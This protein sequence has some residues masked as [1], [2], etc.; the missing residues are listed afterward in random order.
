MAGGVEG[1]EGE[2]QGW[3]GK[4]EARQGKAEQGRAGR[5][6]LEQD[7]FMAGEGEEYG[8]GGFRAA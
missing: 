7:Y 6:G 2:L 1:R 3:S 5:A 8:R 4:G